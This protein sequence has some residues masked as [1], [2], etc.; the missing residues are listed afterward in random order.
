MKNNGYL[1]IRGD[2][3]DQENIKLT[4][5][6][7]GALWQEFVFGTSTDI[8]N[9]YMASIIEDKKIKALF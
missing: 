2:Y 4:S 8:I 3:M 1:I 9:Q 7:V 6:E 5:S